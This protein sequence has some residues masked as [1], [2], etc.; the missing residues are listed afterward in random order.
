MLY[1]KT[2]Q[3]NALAHTTNQWGHQDTTPAQVPFGSLATWDSENEA[4][5]LIPLRV[6]HVTFQR[7]EVIS[8]SASS[9]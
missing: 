7:S 2:V 6:L 4:D 9:Y 3:C 5:P 1:L 8:R